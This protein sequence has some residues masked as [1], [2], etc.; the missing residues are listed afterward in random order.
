M[1]G[2]GGLYNEEQISIKDIGNNI[3][4][5]N[6]YKMCKRRNNSWIDNWLNRLMMPY[7][8]VFI[9]KDNTVQVILHSWRT[10]LF[11]QAY[12]ISSN[13]HK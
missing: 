6:K 4:A 7:R 5:F 3:V 10:L 2:F 8:N 1:H 9:I 12:C 13:N 11:T